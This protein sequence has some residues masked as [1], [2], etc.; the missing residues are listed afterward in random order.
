MGRSL[1]YWENKWNNWKNTSDRFDDEID[2]WKALDLLAEYA[3]FF[4]EVP[5]LGFHMPWGGT[6]GR[7]FA[8]NFNAQY[9]EVV[10]KAISNYFH[11]DGNLAVN[12]IYHTVEYV[13]ALVK[14]EMTWRGK[15]IN[16]ERDD[17]AKILEII[18]DKTKVNYHQLDQNAILY[19][20]A[21]E[22]KSNEGFKF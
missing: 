2:A 21:L 6:I 15:N 5:L 11:Q 18:K 19:K 13:L 8:C 14:A 16:D 10:D 12:N 9:G 3:G 1:E 22:N 20:Y 7:F 17:L 4:K